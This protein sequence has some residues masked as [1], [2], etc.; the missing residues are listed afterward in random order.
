VQHQQQQQQQQQLME[1]HEEEGSGAI[2]SL[3]VTES[4]S[5]NDIDSA[6]H[7]LAFKLAGEKVGVVCMTFG[8]CVC[9]CVC[10]CA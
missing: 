4:A 10:V 1:R 7:A 2:G 5:T 6:L 9:V 8:V 3:S